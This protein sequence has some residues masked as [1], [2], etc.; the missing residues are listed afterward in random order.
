MLP[1]SLY[2]LPLM[3]RLLFRSQKITRP[4]S[5]KSRFPQLP[6]SFVVSVSAPEPATVTAFENPSEQLASR[7][8]WLVLVQ[9]NGA[10]TRMSSAPEPVVI[11]RSPV[12]SM[13]VTSLTFSTAF[14]A[15]GEQT[16]FAQLM[17]CV[18]LVEISTPACAELTAKRARAA[19]AP[20]NNLL[21]VSSPPHINQPS[22][23][24]RTAG[25]RK[26]RAPAR[27]GAPSEA[28]PQD[29]CRRR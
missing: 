25:P 17:F 2:L 19:T 9:L 6:P 3:T 4:L 24:L 15:V 27:T 5:V 23:L 26:R 8:R 20:N 22:T 12:A 1:T 21:T 28:A 11:F 13:P 10:F 18:A 14:C 29:H 16:P 7:V